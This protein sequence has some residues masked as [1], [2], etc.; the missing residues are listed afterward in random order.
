MTHVSTAIVAIL[1]VGFFWLMLTYAISRSWSER[2][3][4]RDERAWSSTTQPRSLPYAQ[5]KEKNRTR[6]HSM[7]HSF[8][9]IK[10]SEPD[11]K[12]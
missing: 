6:N 11:R 7:R 8:A 10:N 1:A 2:M 5:R 9:V 12:P 4:L 3:A